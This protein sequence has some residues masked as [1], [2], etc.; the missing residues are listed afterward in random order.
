M[1]LEHLLNSVILFGAFLFSVV[2]V[3][4]AFTD[5]RRLLK[6]VLYL[7][8]FALGVSATEVLFA[9][10]LPVAS[11]FKACAPSRESLEGHPLYWLCSGFVVPGEQVGY[12]SAGMTG[13]SSVRDVL[14]K[15][16][17]AFAVQGFVLLKLKYDLAKASFA[18][19]GPVAFA[20]FTCAMTGVT[21]LHA[22][23]ILEMFNQV[24][25]SFARNEVTSLECAF[26]W[27]AKQQ[28]YAEAMAN[29]GSWTEQI[30]AG[31]RLLV[32]SLVRFLFTALGFLNLML[33][34][35]QSFGIV[36]LPILFLVAMVLGAGT[37]KFNLMMIGLIS[38]TSM[39]AAAQNL[40]LRW[41]FSES[42]CTALPLD[43][44]FGEKLTA[45]GGLLQ[46][47][48]GVTT[49]Q[50]LGSIQLPMPMAAY[51]STAGF[52]GTSA[53]IAFG[54]FFVMVALVVL[55]NAIGLAVLVKCFGVAISNALGANKIASSLSM[56]D[57][58][59]EV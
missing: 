14:L 45:T 19:P 56:F 2:S 38:S 59:K 32:L 40:A 22:P 51:E 53:G 4:G 7:F 1:M 42:L 52:L 25:V 9:K 24:I 28:A 57:S 58:K 26:K 43:A 41:I 31:F 50:S 37:W 30:V 20:F 11:A 54:I 18:G 15:A 34:G 12:I 49:G 13:F 17:T 10:A 36:L 47:N 8:V 16:S 6:P 3:S 21:L 44:V 46:G 55:A 33:H 48:T 23:Q 29:Q 27:V 39:I 35:L 5:P